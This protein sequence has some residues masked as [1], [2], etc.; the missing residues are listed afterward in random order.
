MWGKNNPRTLSEASYTLHHLFPTAYWWLTI[1]FVCRQAEYW[2]NSACNN[3]WLHS[4]LGGFEWHTNEELDSALPKRLRLQGVCDGNYSHITVHQYLHS[5]FSKRDY[6]TLVTLSKHMRWRIGIMISDVGLSLSAPQIIHCTSLPCPI[7]TT[8][9]CLWTD[10]GQ[11]L[12]CIK[13]HGSC[14]WK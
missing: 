1:S 5:T 6:I 12:A 14:A 2:W 11:N 10:N 8:D 4:V 9:A 13:R 3:V 7:S